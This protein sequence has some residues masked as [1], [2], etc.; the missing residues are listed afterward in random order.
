MCGMGSCFSCL[1]SPST[2]LLFG[3]AERLAFDV[4]ANI[5]CRA[6][7]KMSLGGS[8]KAAATCKVGARGRLAVEGGLGESG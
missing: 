1:S 3:D 2:T 4:L 7:G 8:G 5:A 6:S